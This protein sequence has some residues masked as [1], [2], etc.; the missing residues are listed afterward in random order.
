MTV[1]DLKTMREATVPP[2]AVVC[3]GNFDGVHLGHMALV[4]ETLKKKAELVSSTPEIAAA[5]CFFRILPSDFLHATTIPRLTTFD[6]KLALFAESG[7]DYAFVINFE[8]VGAFSPSE[9]VQ[10]ILQE[11]LH[12][13][14]AV[15]GFNFRFGKNAAGDATLLTHLMSGNVSVVPPVTVN[16]RVICSSAVRQMIADGDVHLVPAILGRPYSLCVDV[17]HGKALG[18]TLG[19]PTIN[20]NFPKALAVPQNGI[21]ITKTTIDGTEYPSVSNIGTRPSVNDGTFINCE[22]HIIGFQ[23]DL[24]GKRIRVQF[25]QRLRDEVRFPNTDALKTQIQNDIQKTKEYYKE[26]LFL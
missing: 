4:R 19:I 25:M 26:A 1:I 20:Q 10:R 9:F 3:L 2:A 5:A 24:Y 13:V 21:Y 15:C 22:T 14:F 6:E 8:N 23:G 7:L 17:L 16:G 12:C 11:A 18:R